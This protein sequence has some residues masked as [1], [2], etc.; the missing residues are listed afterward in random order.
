MTYLCGANKLY[1][2]MRN[3]ISTLALAAS[4]TCLLAFGCERLTNGENGGIVIS[5]A[6][7]NLAEM[8]S[9]SGASSSRADA[10]ALPDP[11]D[12]LVTLWDSRGFEVYRGRYGDSPEVITVP[13]GTYTVQ[14]VSCAFTEPLFDCP[15]WGD[16]QVVVVGGG[17][18]VSVRLRCSQLNSGIRLL[19]EDSFR[20]VFP[21]GTLYLEGEDGVLIYGYS[22]TRTAFFSP[23]RVSVVISD[24]GVDQTLFS[25]S[26]NARQ[27]LEMSLSASVSASSGGVSIE[28][29]T[30][31]NRVSDHYMYGGS[32]AG[33][34]ENA[35]SVS[36]ARDHAGE[37]DVWVCGYIVGVASGTNKF[38]FT[39]PFSRNTNILVGMR[40]GS[41]DPEYL[42]AVELKSGGTRDKLNLADHPSN[43]GRQIYV[44]GDIAA[45]YFGLTGLK[46]VSEYRL[47]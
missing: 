19:V 13:P 9:A 11:S 29:D 23:G 37:K 26:L 47:D 1:A 39:E 15:Q 31:R 18:E 43:R 6:R 14:A 32:G 33:D 24:A 10:G 36:E 12:F 20:D 27:I 21:Y 4:A 38:S 8:R 42:M 3:R 45:S 22:E 41:E 34:I 16:S 44:K 5:F 7:D 2:T 25:R 30:L 17:A 28:L 40:R 46:N 35:Y